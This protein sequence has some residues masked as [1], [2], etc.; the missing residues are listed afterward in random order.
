MKRL[1][2]IQLCI[3]SLLLAFPLQVACQEWPQKTLD[4]YNPFS[5]S[6]A[7]EC[8]KVPGLFFEKDGES[9]LTHIPPHGTT[10]TLRGNPAYRFTIPIEKGSF[11]PIGQ[12][13]KNSELQTACEQ[14][15]K[16]AYLRRSLG[17]K[18]KV[19]VR[20]GNAKVE[21]TEALEV[22]DEGNLCQIRVKGGVSV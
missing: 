18:Y 19:E 21:N 4:Y 15:P 13:D 5:L 8:P 6:N 7:H 1:T 20:A 17:G 14:N 16:I 12:E 22:V 11:I 10:K 2:N 3:I 9:C